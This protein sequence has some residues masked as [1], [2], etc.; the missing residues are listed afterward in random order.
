MYVES[1]NSPS[2]VKLSQQLAEIE[3]QR[4]REENEGTLKNEIKV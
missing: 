4:K 3:E 2:H 1:L